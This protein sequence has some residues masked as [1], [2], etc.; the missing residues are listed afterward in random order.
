MLKL[1]KRA[2]GRITAYHE[3]W[4]DGAHVIEHWGAARRTRDDA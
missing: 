1:Y 3:A 2:N 4:V